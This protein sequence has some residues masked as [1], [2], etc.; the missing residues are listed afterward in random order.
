M[1]RLPLSVLLFCLLVLPA[2]T[3][4]DEPCVIPAGPCVPL[5]DPRLDDPTCTFEVG[6]CISLNWEEYGEAGVIR[7]ANVA[8]TPSCTDSSSA[9]KLEEMGRAFLATVQTIPMT[10]TVS[11]RP[12]TA[13]GSVDVQI[14]ETSGVP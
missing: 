8:V 11:T 6:S 13:K 10:I 12:C 7:K 1:S 9:A 5:S 3:G 14:L 4:A 2:H